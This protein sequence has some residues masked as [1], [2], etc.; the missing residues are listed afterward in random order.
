MT[1]W[2]PAVGFGLLAQF[3]DQIVELGIDVFDEVALQNVKI[4]RAGAHDGGRVGIFDQRQEKVFERRI[5]LRRS[6]ANARAW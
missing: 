2:K 5:F 6:L 1:R 3:R 4:H